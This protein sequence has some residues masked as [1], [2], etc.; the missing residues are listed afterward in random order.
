MG[1][2]EQ[3]MCPGFALVTMGKECVESTEQ[4]Q[5]APLSVGLLLYVAS[6][7]II[8]LRSPSAEK[9]MGGHGH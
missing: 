1:G 5:R 3:G 2:W 8:E 7:L 6:W 4:P 9:D